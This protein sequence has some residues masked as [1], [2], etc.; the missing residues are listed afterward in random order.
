MKDKKIFK[1]IRKKI[2]TYM[3]AP[4]KL[5][6]CLSRNLEGQERSDKIY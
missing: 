3:G 2:L 1:A 4:K 5:N 6:R